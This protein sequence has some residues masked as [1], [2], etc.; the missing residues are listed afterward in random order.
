MVN[1][2]GATDVTVTGSAF[3][4]NV[5]GSANGGKGG[6]GTGILTYPTNA[7]GGNGASAIGGAFDI[8]SLTAATAMV[9]DSP[10]IGNMAIAGTGGAGVQPDAFGAAGGSGGNG[11]LAA[12]GGIASENYNF[13]FTSTT[14]NARR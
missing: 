11:G 3:T 4:G 9:T 10:I 12:G 6:A 14:L 8:S 1:T 5:A 13:T 2:V 7:S